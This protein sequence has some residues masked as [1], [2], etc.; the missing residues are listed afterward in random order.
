MDTLQSFSTA[1]G[2]WYM[3]QEVGTGTPHDFGTQ[4]DVRVGHM[5]LIFKRM[6]NL[7]RIS[8]FQQ[9]RRLVTFK[10]K[11]D[12]VYTV[13][14]FRFRDWLDVDDFEQNEGLGTYEVIFNGTGDLVHA[15]GSGTWHTSVTFKRI[16]D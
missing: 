12:L 8:D 14:F 15:T 11:R 13:V 7:V 4:R 16:K 1:K 6:E 3:S 5:S 9:Y 10:T 2:V